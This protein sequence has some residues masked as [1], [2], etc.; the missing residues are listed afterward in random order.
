MTNIVEE[1]GEWRRIAERPER[2]RASLFAP[3]LAE[4]GLTDPAVAAAL[5]RLCSRPEFR[6]AARRVASCLRSA[7][8][9]ERAV[10]A[11]EDAVAALTELR[12]DAS[13]L[14][15][16]VVLQPFVLLAGSSVSAARR[17]ARDPGLAIELGARAEALLPKEDFAGDIQ[18]ILTASGADTAR[19]DRLL[20]RFRHRRMLSIALR[21]IRGADLRETSREIAD[22]AGAT[23]EAALRHHRAGLEAKVGT[24]SPACA[25]VIIGMGK[26]GGREL[27]F[28]SDVDLIFFYEHDEAMAGE[29]SAHEFHVKLLERV[30]ASMS[31]V[32]EHGFVF[33][34]DMNLRPEGRRGALAN[35]L[36]SAERYY[37]TWGRTWER[38]AWV[39]ARPV[40]GDL[41]FGAQVQEMMR[42]FV[43]RRS[44]DLKAIEEIIGM[45]ERIDEARSLAALSPLGG[46]LDLKLGE[47]GIREVEFFVQAQQLLHGGRDPMLRSANTLEA[48]AALET[49][50][51]VSAR[52][53][54]VL[55][56]AYLLF[57]RVEHRVQIVDE[58]QTHH[59]P[60]SPEDQA[61]LARSL[62]LGSAE[63]L[64][65]ALAAAM[66]E[67]H[68]QFAGLMGVAT[69]EEPT[70]PE[71]D[72]LLS[73]EL[74]PDAQADAWLRLGFID[75]SAAQAGLDAAARFPASP[76]HPRAPTAARRVARR[77]LFECTRSPSPDRALRHLPDLL[78]AASVHRA[79]LDELSRPEL[80]RGVTRV[81]GASDLLARIL[82]AS[83][84]LISHVLLPKA[85]PPLPQL[86]AEA[87]ARVQAVASDPEEALAVLRSVKQEET[88]RTALFDMAGLIQA[89]AVGERLSGLA[90]LLIQEALDLAL[91]QTRARYGVP[92]QADGS[93]AEVCLVGGGTLGARE[94]SYRTDVDLSVIYRGSGETT[95]GAR[96]KVSVGEF[97]TRVVQRL[98]QILTLRTPQ[99]D[100]YPVDMRLRPSGTQGPLVAS[101]HSFQSYHEKTAQLWER[102]ALVRSRSVA[103]AEGLRQV[104]DAAI[105][106]ATYGTPAPADAAAS[107]RDMRARLAR[108]NRRG[109]DADGVIDL[110]H[111]DG[112]LMEL[113]FL[114]QYLLL[115]HGHTHPA[116]R[117]TSSRTALVRLAELELLPGEVAERLVLAQ[118]RLRRVQN[119]LRVTHDE[120][121]DRVL[122]QNPQGLAVL[123]RTVGYGGDEA[124]TRLVHDV[125]DDMSFVH[126]VWR[127]RLG[128]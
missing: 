5:G 58:Q 55:T 73:R 54:Q 109:A 121:V 103:G 88:L 13:P 9:P 25:C 102:Q 51:L 114:V 42:P 20:R 45:K 127:E 89:P 70:P 31:R 78:R 105:T 115:E 35:S 59:L 128:G 111:G 82:V 29:L 60:E 91:E 106:Q 94:M 16:D 63:T 67:V 47:G 3:R 41:A 84:G 104:V 108:E 37:E 76:F 101:L 32:T 79:N 2:E 53:R 112:G 15:V 19:F 87:K 90:E 75:P 100:L 117:T 1:D 49:R 64:R 48:L 14:L 83:P 113:D 39:R 69:D 23:L 8:S 71:L 34:V 40:A 56:S 27:N 123:A 110:K 52:T 66:Q 50:G 62:Q 43:W 12:G 38:A 33:R 126:A 4:L 26:L 46:G 18:Q 22:L 96:G 11:L 24:L 77:L 120:I 99:G 125:R 68:E 6:S 93:P 74:E 10:H 116:V 95:G 17:M 98:L 107:I 72:L 21:E 65:A 85:L 92:T 118:E 28:S 119:W 61:V 124:S 97:Y 30:I 57:R 81:L 80:V 7:A 86:A 36:A 122:L 44:F